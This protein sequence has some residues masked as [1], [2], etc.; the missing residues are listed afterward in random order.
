MT[1]KADVLTSQSSGYNNYD[2]DAD[3][4]TADDDDCGGNNNDGNEDDDDT[5]YPDNKYIRKK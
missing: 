2:N 4:D 5:N 1:P 3:A